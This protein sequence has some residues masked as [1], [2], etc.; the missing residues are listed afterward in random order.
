MSS[1]PG[2][3]GRCTLF[4]D[5]RL[6]WKDQTGFVPA[7]AFDPGNWD[8]PPRTPAHRTA[9]GGQGRRL[10]FPLP[11]GEGWEEEG[12]APKA[13]PPPPYLPK[14]GRGPFVR[15]R[16]N[17]AGEEKPG[18]EHGIM[19]EK[20]GFMGLGIMGRAMAANIARAGYPLT[21]YNRTPGKW[22]ALEELEV[23]TAPSPEALA[24]KSDVVIAMVTGPEALEQLLWGEKGAARAFEPGKVFINMSTV[25]PSYTKDLDRRLASTG[26]IFLD[27]PVSGSKKPAGDG[28]LLILAG[29]PEDSVE[30]LT[31][32]L[33]TMGS[34]VIYCGRVGQGSMMKMANNLLLTLMIEGLAEALNFGRKGGLS[35]E[36]VL[37][38]VLNGPLGC[39]IFQMKGRAFAE[40]S[41]DPNFPLKHAAKDLKFLVDTA[42]ELGAPVPVGHTL[43]HLYR[44]GVARKWGDLDIGAILKVLEHLNPAE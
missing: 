5:S 44:A 43:L 14:R 11:R 35:D 18:K 20:I 23:E 17:H 8:A 28:T 29:G 1:D 32:L 34:Q 6:C 37:E 41:F 22:E 7:K 27:A 36:A 33:K 26:V 38:V 24:E 19:K 25:S 30:A 2:I 21:V 39:P 42:Y 16:V 4:P 40:R 3:P 13:P 31:P 9:C 12:S 10:G 15:P